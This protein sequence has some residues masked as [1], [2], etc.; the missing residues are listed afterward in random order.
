MMLVLQKLLPRALFLFSSWHPQVTLAQ[1][2]LGCL[3]T[4]T[5]AAAAGG[6]GGS[7]GAGLAAP[8]G[9]VVATITA[10]NVRFDNALRLDR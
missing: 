2:E 3:D 6:L 8:A 10:R 9:P 4:T 5:A 7:L 1:L